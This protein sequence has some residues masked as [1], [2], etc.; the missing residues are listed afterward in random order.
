MVTFTITRRK[1]WRTSEKDCRFGLVLLGFL[2]LWVFSFL[3]LLVLFGWLVAFCLFFVFAIKVIRPKSC[4]YNSFRV[5]AYVKN[6]QWS[7]PAIGVSAA[8]SQLYL[9]SVQLLCTD[10]LINWLNTDRMNIGLKVVQHKQ[11]LSGSPF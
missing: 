9:S 8:L 5:A 4:L 11:K 6:K 3:V 7:W 2:V 1:V 10:F